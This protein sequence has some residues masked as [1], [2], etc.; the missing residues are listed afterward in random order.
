M[1]F[2]KMDIQPRHSYPGSDETSA[3]VQQAIQGAKRHERDK[4]SGSLSESLSYTGKH[5]QNATALQGLKCKFRLQNMTYLTV[6]VYGAS[7]SV[8][9]KRH[10]VKLRCECILRKEGHPKLHTKNWTKFENKRV[11]WSS[12]RPIAAASCWTVE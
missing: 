9:Q 3:E 6:T 11:K 12:A 8:K 5:R 10:W 2:Y 4:R 1:C 7:F